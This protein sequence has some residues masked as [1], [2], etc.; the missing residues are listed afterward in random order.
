LR[1][2]RKEF[3]NTANRTFR[4]YPLGD[5][6][7]G[8]KGCDEAKLARAIAEIEAD[9]DGYWIGTGDYLDAINR[10][11]KRFDPDQLADWM[12]L[13]DLSDI[14]R[15]QLRRFRQLF[16]PISHKCLGLTMGNHEQTQTRIYERNVY[17]DLIDCIKQ[18]A[19]FDADHPLRL[20]YS[21]WLLPSF[22][23]SQNRAGGSRQLRFLIHHGAGGGGRTA[24]SVNKLEGW[25]YSHACDVALMGHTHKLA[26]TMV[27][28]ESVSRTGQLSLRKRYGVVASTFLRGHSDTEDDGS[29]G[30]VKMYLP[31]PTGRVK[32]EVTPHAEDEDDRLRVITW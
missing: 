30:E 31:L 3:F 32:I 5:L 27:G 23:K 24:S 29:Y 9:E 11:D 14:N 18:E 22:F 17:L 28:V 16:A 12:T 7:L 13:R 2:V 1:V 8:V 25:L 21:G 10:N 26:S 15:A 6:H 20:G 19:G 4:F